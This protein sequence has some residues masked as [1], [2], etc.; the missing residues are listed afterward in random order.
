MVTRREFL[1]TLAVG[2]AGLAVSTTAKSY[3]QIMGANDR[4]NFAV[5]GLNS[6]AYAHLS[7]LQANKA[8]ARI[9]YVCDVES[10]ILAKFAGKTEAAM[11]E[12]PVAVKD[13]REVLAKKDVDAITIATPDHWHAPM[14]IRGLQAGK[15]VYVEKPCS[16]NPGEGALLVKAQQKYGKLVQMGTQQRSS[17]HT[18]EIVDK[19]HNGLIGRAYYAKAWY[20]NTRKSI[21]HGKEAP[22]PATLDWDLWQGPAPRQAYRDNVQPYNW[23]WFRIW[24]TG[25]TLNNGTHEIDV[26]RWAL[27]VQYPE[28]VTAA[29][30]RY[31]Y[32]DDWQFYDTLNTSLD[33]GDKTISWEGKCCNGMRFYGRDR[34]SAIMGETGSVVVDRGGYEIYD[35]KGNKTDEKKA[36]SQESSSDLVGADSM[37][38][39]HFANFIAGIQKGEKLNAPIAV[40]NVSVT[41]MQLSN[42]AW[43]VNREL[44]TDPTDAHILN[45]AEAMKYWD[46]EYEKGWAPHL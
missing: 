18:I 9:A 45:D 27:D 25:E 26:C 11:G 1:D 15:H 39:A 2:A 35:L 42:I 7:S 46:R 14:A 32:K 4:L 21:G 29:G 38:D 31:A 13:F 36:A 3:A 23:H 17:Q 34:G 20:S 30:G 12:K 19:I 10:N 44:R 43:F 16:H 24:G 41:S 33:Y 5:I 28:R 40:G 37:T 6:R 8:H 22:V